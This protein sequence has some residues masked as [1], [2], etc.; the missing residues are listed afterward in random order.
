MQR[1]K[2]FVGASATVELEW[3]SVPHDPFHH[4]NTP[5]DFVEAAA[6]LHARRT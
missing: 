4:V 3:L 5:E 2:D 1:V 6:V